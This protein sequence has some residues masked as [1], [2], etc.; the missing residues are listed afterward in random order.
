MAQKNDPFKNFLEK[1]FGGEPVRIEKPIGGERTTTSEERE[2]IARQAAVPAS[3]AEREEESGSRVTE[4][5]KKVA[6]R[7]KIVG[8]GPVRNMNF[9]I[10]DS[11]R[12]DLELLKVMQ[13]RASLTELL[14]EA[15]LDLLKKYGVSGY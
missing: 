10:E 14:N 9:C 2:V 8:R 15:I 7:P 13:H 11:V 1:N 3:N 4:P 5:A 6:G 12:Y